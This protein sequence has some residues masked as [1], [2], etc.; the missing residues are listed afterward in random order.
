M[1]VWTYFVYLDTHR[2]IVCC[3]VLQQCVAAVCCSVL[4][5]VAVC[6]SVSIHKMCMHVYIY[7]F[8]AVCSR[9][10][11]H[12]CGAFCLTVYVYVYVYMNVYVY[13]YARVCAYFFCIL[14]NTFYV[15]TDSAY[16][17]WVYIFCGYI[18]FVWYGHT[19]SVRYSYGVATVS[20]IDKIIGLFCRISSLL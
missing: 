7:M 12:C 1:Y 8:Y 17:F 15:Y 6:C 9:H 2:D 16:L 5:C 20:R 18:Y 10:V 11:L 13:L 14:T 19:C 4:Q 3:I